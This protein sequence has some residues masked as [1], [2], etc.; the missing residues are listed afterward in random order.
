MEKIVWIENRCGI[1]YYMDDAGVY[2]HPADVLV[3]KPNPR[4]I[5][6]PAFPSLPLPL[7]IP[8]PQNI[9]HFPEQKKNRKE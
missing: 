1:L 2:Y 3:N 6:A 9:C 7:P 8:F 5:S 4:V